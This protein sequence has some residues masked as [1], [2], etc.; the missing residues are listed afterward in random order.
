MDGL[1]CQ[2]AAG[3]VRSLGS[4]F[5]RPNFFKFLFLFFFLFF[6]DVF[7]IILFFLFLKIFHFLRPSIEMRD[8]VGSDVASGS[9]FLHPMRLPIRRGWLPGEGW[10][11]LL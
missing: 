1:R 3:S 11:A 9:L 2:T 5:S 4:W 10:K 6:R 8:C 7:V